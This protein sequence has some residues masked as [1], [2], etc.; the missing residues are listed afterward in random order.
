[1]EKRGYLLLFLASFC[2]GIMG[3]FIRLLNKEIPPLTQISIRYVFMAIFSFVLLKIGKKQIK[4]VSRRDLILIILI[5]AFAYGFTNVFFCLA[6]LNT[7]LSTAYFLNSTY[8]VFTPFLSFFLLKEKLPLKVMVSI[9]LAGVGSYI[10]FNPQS[11]GNLIGLIYAIITALLF[12]F[13]LIGRRFLKK[14]SSELMMFYLTAFGA[15]SVGLSSLILEK[16]FI[17]FSHGLN[18]I[19]LSWFGWFILLL[20]TIDAYI[21][22]FLVNKGMALAPAGKGSLI[23]MLESVWGTLV[24]VIAYH[25]PLTFLSICGAALI[26]FSSYLVVK[27]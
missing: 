10:L 8:V 24:G 9:F 3:V 18:F 14:Y 1:M 5:S 11:G 20:F 23:L 21:T 6:A 19:Q 2:Y 7:T 27:N 4:I 16:N 17:F 12:S 26:L 25:E 22:W 13:Y 15:L